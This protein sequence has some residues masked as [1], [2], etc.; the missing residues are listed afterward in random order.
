M[1]VI[2]IVQQSAR[3]S[4]RVFLSLAYPKQLQ[5]LIH[6]RVEER[7]SE[8][9]RAGLVEYGVIEDFL[10]EGEVS[11]VLPEQSQSHYCPISAESSR[12]SLS[13]VVLL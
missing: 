13:F 12:L 2:Q 9:I 8:L 1:A 5:I 10:F 4:I 6:L 7:R 11:Q 3:L